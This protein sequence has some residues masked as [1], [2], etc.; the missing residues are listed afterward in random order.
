M[1]RMVAIFRDDFALR[2]VT[3]FMFSVILM[4]GFYVQVHGDFSPG[5]GFQGGVIVASAIIMY[6]MVFGDARIREV[7]PNLVTVGTIGLFIYIMTG[8]VSIFFGG[9]F[10]SYVFSLF[11]SVTEQKL[12]VFI[13]ELGVGI[14]V[15]ASIAS[16]YFDFAS[17][18]NDIN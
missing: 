6:A 9:N 16:V 15:C 4:Y 10:L 3:S 1:S 12:G 13:V 5:G 2:Y 18:K 7:L 14:T 11:D 8:V 17:L